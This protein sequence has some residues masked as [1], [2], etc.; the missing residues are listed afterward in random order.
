M[1]QWQV[2]KYGRLGLKYFQ[3]VIYWGVLLLFLQWEFFLAKIWSNHFSNVRLKYPPCTIFDIPKRPT[4]YFPTICNKF[5][6]KNANAPLESIPQ[7]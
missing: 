7:L 1:L 2:R 4:G 6:S 3:S 5:L